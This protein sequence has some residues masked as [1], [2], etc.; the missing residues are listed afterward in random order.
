[1][2][3]DVPAAVWSLN[4]PSVLSEP[5]GPVGAA[6]L[7]EGGWNPARNVLIPGDL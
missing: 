4:G 3:L 6:T 2:G 1:M 5:P 7:A